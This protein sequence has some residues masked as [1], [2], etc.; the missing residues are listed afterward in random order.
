M[1]HLSTPNLPKSLVPVE[2]TEQPGVR[3]WSKGKGK[4]EIPDS[5][6]NININGHKGS[7]VRK[8]LVCS[9]VN[10]L[11]KSVAK[12]INQKLQEARLELATVLAMLSVDRQTFYRQLQSLIWKIQN[13]TDVDSVL[14]CIRG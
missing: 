4:S 3:S 13:H 9:V 12:V 14:S 5:S 6:S 1:I 10:N 8:A 11:E 2:S 7:L